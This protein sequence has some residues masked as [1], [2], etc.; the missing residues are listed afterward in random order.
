MTTSE[1]STKGISNIAKVLTEVYAKA[2]TY[3]AA[4]DVSI[5]RTLTEMSMSDFL[6]LEAEEG[7]EL[8]KGDV[9]ELKASVEGMKEVLQ[10]LATALDGANGKLDG[11]KAAIAELAGEIPDPG[12]LAG[13]IIDPNPNEIADEAERINGAVS[14]AASAAAS[15]VEAIILFS[16]NLSAAVE[17]VPEEMRA[18]KTLNDLSELAKAKE[19]KT[20]DGTEIKFPDAAKLRSAAQKAI[21][22]SLIQI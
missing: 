19:L 22:L 14:N 8:T 16:E 17:D 9:E 13:M 20:T 7:A 15:V 21:A 3:E 6:L 2:L 12:T 1:K 4:S 11:T 5:E 10:N 18:D